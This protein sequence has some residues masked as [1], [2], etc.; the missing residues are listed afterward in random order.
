VKAIV[1]TRDRVTYAKQTCHALA[2][3][4]LDVHIVDHG[5]SWGPM[6]DWLH[7][8]EYP[9]FRC[10][11][12]T[13]RDL[14]GRMRS[15]TLE[16]IVPVGERYVVSDPDVVPSLGCDRGWVDLAQ[17]VLSTRP[18]IVKCGPGLR[19]DDLPFNVFTDRV[20][21]WER[22]FWMQRIDIRGDGLGTLAPV[23]S[24]P[25][26][27]TCAL[28]RPWNEQDFTLGP[29]ARLGDPYTFRHLPWYELELTQEIVWYRAHAL[30]GASHWEPQR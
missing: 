6:L 24:A 5:S 11:D 1:I 27:T 26:D 9:V 23:Y 13:P 28:Y 2:R 20:K 8:Q 12:A 10:G 7:Y 25:I 29:S 17:E 4:G 18:E 21:E 19:V 15:V 30:E 16:K 3:M 14:W 22:Q